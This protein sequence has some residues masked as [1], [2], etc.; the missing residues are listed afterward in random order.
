MSV[1][2][3]IA[4]ERSVLIVIDVQ[5]VVARQAH[6]GGGYAAMAAYQRISHVRE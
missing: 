1:Q 2:P 5:T 6:A 4:A 3:L